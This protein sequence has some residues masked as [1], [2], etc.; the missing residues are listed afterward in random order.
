MTDW[1]FPVID[2]LGPTGVG[3]LVLLE[4]LIPPIPSEVVLPLA[5]FRART[6][7]MHP[8]II[9]AAATAGSLLGALLLY[10]LGAWI[11]YDRLHRLA[12][13]RWFLLT[14]P[15]DLDRGRRLFDRH[16]AWIVV[17]ARCV[18]VLRS[19]I[20]LPAGVARMPLFRFATLTT[21]GAGTWNAVFITVGWL[22]ADNWH[23]VGTYTR[24]AGIAMTIVIGVAVAF[25]AGRK[26]RNH[27]RGED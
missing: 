15:A 14:S 2:K 18:P 19:L 24:P 23:Q 20:S 22:L 21:A 12:E 6:G 17:V 16:G 27:S 10:G 25:L 8:V 26:L 3:V 11:G 9:W 13:Q 4:N 5:G 7:A 1:I